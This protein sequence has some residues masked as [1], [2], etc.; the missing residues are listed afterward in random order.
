M[1][2][3]F[4]L[5]P[6]LTL[7]SHFSNAQITQIGI[8]GGL[9]YA[10]FKTNNFDTKAI[11]SYHFGPTVNLKLFKGLAVQGE[12]LYSTVGGKYKKPVDQIVKEYKNELGYLSIPLSLQVNLSNNVYIE[13]GPQFSFL[14]SNKNEFDINND[15]SFD[16]GIFGGI[17]FRLLKHVNLGARY[18]GGT[19]D[20]YSTN[21][22]KNNVV[23]AFVEIKF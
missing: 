16:L 8:K 6:V 4:F 7:F 15:N 21:E 19:T 1:K 2:R 20:V 22:S 3:I 12:I 17:G 23:Q 14:L 11:T 5:I 9:N 13:A 18:I 10:N